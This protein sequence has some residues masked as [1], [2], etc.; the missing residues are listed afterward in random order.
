[1][2]ASAS[3]DPY[4]V[5]GVAKDATEEEIRAAHRA[6]IRH[7]HPDIGGNEALARIINQA[8]DILLERLAPGTSAPW[9]AQP[10]RAPDPAPTTEPSASTEDTTAVGDPEDPAPGASRDQR[11][12]LAPYRRWQKV[13][14]AVLALATAGL[15]VGIAIVDSPLPAVA[16][17]GVYAVLAGVPLGTMTVFHPPPTWMLPPAMAGM[18]LGGIGAFGALTSN[19]LPGLPLMAALVAFGAI[20]ARRWYGSPVL[21]LGGGTLDALRQPQT[22]PARDLLGRV[23]AWEAVL[24][25]TLLVV[26][27][28]GI[29]VAV[30]YF[31]TSIL[32]GLVVIGVLVWLFTSRNDSGGICGYPARNGPCRNNAPCHIDFHRQ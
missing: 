13:G 4:Q 32:P 30:H 29:V 31:V 16:F 23:K 19:P 26:S 6:Q 14:Y 24:A 15:F 3:F 18:G 21:R 10:P 8:R 2:S 25:I 11:W 22:P 20:T 17:V 1:M 7:L 9:T 28:W 27:V 5:L 12:Q